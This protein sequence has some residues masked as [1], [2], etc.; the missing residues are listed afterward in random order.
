[1]DANDQ[2]NKNQRNTNKRTDTG[3][4]NERG[5]G[6]ICLMTMILFALILTT[7]AAPRQSQE[8]QR[9]NEE[10]ML[11]RGQQVA[12]AIKRYRM[13]K[14]GIFPTDLNELTK[15]TEVNGKRIRFLRPSALCDPMMPCAGESNWRLVHPGDPL[16]K[17]LLDAVVA[18]QEKS[19][20]TINPQGI[21]ELARFAQMVLTTLPRQPAGARLDGKI[22]PTVD[23]KAGSGSGLGDKKAPIIGVVSRKRGKMLRSYYGIDEYDHAFFFPDIPVLASD[24]NN[25]YGIG[26]GLIGIGTSAG[27]D[28]QCPQGG[29][30]V[31]GKCYGAVL[32]GQLC[33]DPA[34][35]KP[36][37]CSSLKK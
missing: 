23:P 10:E 33:R 28:P 17:E 30:L 16:A 9:E 21:Q 7:A 29:V 31:D 24:F 12:L 37:P 36:V 8:T 34:T 22:S 26:G 11:W 13:F 3:K 4:R 35:Q 27:K 14:G 6:L 1:M 25:P 20:I 15:V 32:R 2:T 18:S 5:Y 19:Q